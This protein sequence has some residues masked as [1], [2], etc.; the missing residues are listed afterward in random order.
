MSDDCQNPFSNLCNDKV[1]EFNE[2]S[3]NECTDLMP[4]DSNFDAT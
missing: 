2:I 3:D 4:I 1:I